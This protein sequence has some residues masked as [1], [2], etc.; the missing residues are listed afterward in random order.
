M[1]DT[2][3]LSLW[4]QSANPE[5][6]ILFIIFQSIPEFYAGKTVAITGGTGFVGQCVIEK[7]LRSC[8]DVKKI[9][10]LLRSKRSLSAEERLKNLTDLPVSATRLLF[11]H[12]SPAGYCKRFSLTSLSLSL[13]KQLNCLLFRSKLLFFIQIFDNVRNAHPGFQSKLVAVPCDLEKDGFG[14]GEES[15]QLLQNETNIFLHSAATVKFT[16][17]LR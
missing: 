17:H 16:E 10:V 1:N 9:L 8:P 5:Y 14:L 11:I 7:L 13:G 12:R 15:L 3:W 6:S 4:K 2:Q